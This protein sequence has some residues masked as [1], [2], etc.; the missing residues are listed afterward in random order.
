[1]KKD[2]TTASSVTPVYQQID[3]ATAQPQKKQKTHKTYTEEQ[4][5][6][7]RAAGLTQGRRGVK[8]RRIN[9]AFDDD[10][11]EYIQTMARVRGETLTAF[12]NAVFRKSMEDNAELYEK[13]KAFKE[14]L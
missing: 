9:M 7:L 2:F 10:I 12:T 5:E 1:M 8:M 4:Q 6:A 14:M 3:Q 11:H 13:A